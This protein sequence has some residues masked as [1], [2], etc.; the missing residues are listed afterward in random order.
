M[1]D[2]LGSVES[3]NKK[4]GRIEAKVPP[5]SSL[6]TLLPYGQ[7]QTARVNILLP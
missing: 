1:F 6:D 4:G 3:F 2:M 7:A 5:S